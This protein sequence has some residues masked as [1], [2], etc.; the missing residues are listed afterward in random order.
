MSSKNVSTHYK[1]FEK[2]G[3]YSRRLNN[4]DIFSSP[5]KKITANY[6]KLSANSTNI[7]ISTT[8]LMSF[9]PKGTINYI[10]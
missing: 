3:L 4:K 1:H 7:V 8:D 9:S 2:I 5:L 10:K 6:R